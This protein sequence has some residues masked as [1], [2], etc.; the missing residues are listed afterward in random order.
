[1]KTWKGRTLDLAINDH[2]TDSE[3][4]NW[5]IE[6]KSL[7]A[8]ASEMG[9]GDACMEVSRMML[10]GELLEKARKIGEFAGFNAF[11]SNA[12]LLSLC[13]SYKMCW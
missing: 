13:T 9:K 12:Y 3:K 4:I 11:A 7:I 2:L 1:M 10:V 8:C 6:A 5:I